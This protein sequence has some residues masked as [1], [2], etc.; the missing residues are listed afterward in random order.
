[1]THTLLTHNKREISSSRLYFN[2]RTVELCYPWC[3]CAKHRSTVSERLGFGALRIRIRRGGLKSTRPRRR[4]LPKACE[5]SQ[6]AP[7]SHF[8]QNSI[9][10]VEFYNFYVRNDKN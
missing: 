7:F 8:L 3:P 2:D 9:S 6:I 5:S 4:W 10:S 1:M